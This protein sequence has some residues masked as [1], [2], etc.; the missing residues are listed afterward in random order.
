MPHDMQPQDLI[1]KYFLERSFELY[2]V[3]EVDE[4]RD[5]VDFISGLYGGIMT[6]RTLS[7]LLD[8]TDS[9]MEPYKWKI[10]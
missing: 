7:K 8:G 10:K 4:A 1:G 3:I 5:R 6:S 9:S 2:R